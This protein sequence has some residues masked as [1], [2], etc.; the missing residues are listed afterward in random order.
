M[1]FLLVAGTVLVFPISLSLS[2][3]KTDI[4]LL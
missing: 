1:L 2:T 4:F 3:E